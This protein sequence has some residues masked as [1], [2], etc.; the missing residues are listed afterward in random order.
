M[1]AAVNDLTDAQR[2]EIGRS[3]EQAW[4][5]MMAGARALDAA[6][7][8]A[9][10]AEKPTQV[11][12]GVIVED[13]N[14]Q[15]EGTRRWLESLRQLDATYDHVH[16]EVLAPAAAVATMNHHLSWSDTTGATGQWHS[17]WTAV[18]RI[19]EGQWKIVHSHESV[20]PS[21]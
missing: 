17:A 12:N 2:V 6:R 5:E 10:Y 4:S 3:V 14:N 13:F 15:F 1:T 9:R 19:I 8:R 21:P 18:F 7:I 11:V 20:P 16:L